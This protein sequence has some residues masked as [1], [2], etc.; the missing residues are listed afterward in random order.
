MNN[1]YTRQLCTDSL[2]SLG[3]NEELNFRL[4]QAFFTLKPMVNKDISDKNWE[5]YVE[6]K[7]EFDSID[8]NLNL[9][10]SY[11]IIIDISRRL[12]YLILD[13]IED[14]E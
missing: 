1:S 3:S 9:D 12:I 6:L 8:N 13:I 5:T 14:K 4:R 2:I 11:E 10:N 7:T